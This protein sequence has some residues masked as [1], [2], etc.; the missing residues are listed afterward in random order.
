ME[1]INLDL[2]LIHKAG[3]SYQA[4]LTTPDDKA[5]IDFRRPVSPVELNAFQTQVDWARSTALP[6][7]SQMLRELVES[8]GVRLFE[9]LFRDEVWRLFK[10]S[11]REASPNQWLRLRLDLS[12]APDLGH[13]PWEY[14]YD[15]E[16]DQFLALTAQTSLLRYYQYPH[17]IYPLR[18]AA[19]WRLLLMTSPNRDAAAQRRQLGE[20]L[21]PF[22]A[23]GIYE[24]YPPENETN[25]LP[26]AKVQ[27]YHILHFVGETQQGKLIVSDRNGQKQI[28]DAASLKK[29][30]R[31]QRDLRLVI[32]DLDPGP[33]G[34][35]ETTS[36]AL[37]MAQNLLTNGVVGVI[38]SFF[39]GHEQAG[40]T[41]Y[42]TFFHALSEYKPLDVA[43]S[44]G[45]QVLADS[46]E[47][48]EWAL[49]ILHLRELNGKIFE[50][51]V[52]SVQSAKELWLSSEINR[53]A[54]E[55]IEK[56][57]QLD[58]NEGWGA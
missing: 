50:K 24:L 32:L 31:Q 16:A 17:R 20:T 10:M 55:E 57:R 26:Q 56:G 30:M 40:A 28:I 14:L 48:L 25:L 11:Q 21:K 7:A 23:T 1:F 37:E 2:R 43:L 45:R 33:I 38:T 12:A 35:S 42:Q 9:V 15:P 44:E 36:S 5:T 53:A 8:F 27:P 34:S 47:G 52:L 39:K 46:G 3:R 41:F 54:A 18:V 19:P 58:S 29:F 6:D 4:K 49:P 13:L 22:I 51:T